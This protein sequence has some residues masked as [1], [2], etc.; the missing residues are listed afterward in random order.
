[1]YIWGAL[2]ESADCEGIATEFHRVT[3]IK[4]EVQS[5]YLSHLIR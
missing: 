2:L 3:N 5:T 4:I 1:M